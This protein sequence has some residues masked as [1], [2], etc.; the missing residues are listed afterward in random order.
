MVAELTLKVDD[1]GQSLVGW[2]SGSF[3]MKWDYK[4]D[5]LKGMF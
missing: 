4:S 3:N 5:E 1:Y 2:W